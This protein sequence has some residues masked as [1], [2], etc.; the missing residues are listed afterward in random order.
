MVPFVG[1]FYVD[2][3]WWEVAVPPGETEITPGL[4]LDFLYFQGSVRIRPLHDGWTLLRVLFAPVLPADGME[5]GFERQLEDRMGIEERRRLGGLGL[6]LG[7][8][9]FFLDPGLGR[10]AEGVAEKEGKKKREPRPN[11]ERSPG[12]GMNSWIWGMSTKLGKAPAFSQVFLPRNGILDP[13]SGP[14]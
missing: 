9:V 14:R 3:E 4:D 2:A 8:C 10:D 7:R 1:S 12:Q 13:D 6:L 11:H 5:V